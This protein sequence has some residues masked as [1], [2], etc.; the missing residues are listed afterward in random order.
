M[1]KFSK[2]HNTETLNL[3]NEDHQNLFVIGTSESGPINEPIRI[4]SLQDV[5]SYFGNTGSLIESYRV[6]EGCLQNK[7][8]DLNLYL[9]KTSGRYSYVNIGS[10]L[11]IRTT[12]TTPELSEAIVEVKGKNIIFFYPNMNIERV[13]KIR[14]EQTLQDINSDELNPAMVHKVH[15]D[16][17]DVLDG[18]YK[19]SI[20]KQGLDLNKNELFMDLRT[21]LELLEGLQINNIVLPD[22]YFDD[23]HPSF[24]FE[25][26]KHE[27]E[28]VIITEEKDTLTLTEGKEETS[29]HKLLSNFCRKQLGVGVSTHGFI[30]VSPKDFSHMSYEDKE[31]FV[32]KFVENFVSKQ[33]KTNGCF[34]SVA[35]GDVDYR[36]KLSSYSLVLAA[37][38]ALSLP[39]ES[40]TNK[41]LPK[42]IVRFPTELSDN[43]L[44]LLAESG[45]STYRYSF[46]NGY[47]AY[48]TTTFSNPDS[49]YFYLETIKT[50]G[51]VV[52]K[53]NK[54]MK[55]YI[56]KPKELV[57]SN[58]DL[59]K[60]VENTLVLLKNNNTIEDY[61]F[62]FEVVHDGLRLKLE[63]TTVKHLQKLK[64]EQGF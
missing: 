59:I 19:F 56:G 20:P 3:I 4:S 13:Y 23:H 16:I 46:L 12:T 44:K 49:D 11:E 53:L 31:S 5:I 64:I 8:H 21:T 48:T 51:H 2:E 9:V 40:I 36:G 37:I 29:F 55:K 42:S 15:G 35:F 39:Q 22:V 14:G 27:E 52:Y 28:K 10:I 6:L 50:A 32:N 41:K 25:D 45:L 33:R 43:S 24:T 62:K 63:L 34:I 18:V 1:R 17:D 26:F 61:E 38:S 57:L 30:G 58:T 60:T 47:V 7:M 54:A